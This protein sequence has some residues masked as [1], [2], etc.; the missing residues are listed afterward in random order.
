MQRES[1]SNQQFNSRDE[2]KKIHC[3]NAT[4]A[5]LSTLLLEFLSSQLI[6]NFDVLSKA[7]T[8]RSIVFQKVTNYHTTWF[9]FLMKYSFHFDDTGTWFLLFLYR[10]IQKIVE[11][12]FYTTKIV[13][14][15]N[16]GLKSD[17]SLVFSRRCITSTSYVSALV[18]IDSTM[19][20]WF[21][22]ADYLWFTA[23][24]E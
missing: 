1:L 13:S 12:F 2:K 7:E 21:A 23:C 3:K 19:I 8:G 9:I 20:G 24:I 16:Q 17:F 5:Q 18:S 11:K 6:W 22:I 14:L 15:K 4:K 10:F